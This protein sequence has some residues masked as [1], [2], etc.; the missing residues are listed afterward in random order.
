MAVK[1]IAVCA[2]DF[3]LHDGIDNAVLALA[4]QGRL[5]GV[6]CLVG[7]PAWV[8]GAQRLAGL[9]P[10]RIDI[11]LHLDLTEMPL[12]RR[13]R[14]AL[15]ALIAAACARR[16][17]RTALRAE[18][19]AQL[20]RFEQALGRP[21]A[22]IDGHQHVQQLPQV[23]DALFDV[24]AGRRAATRPWLRC[25]LRPV[26]LQAPAGAAAMQAFKPW[27]IETLGARAFAT[28][29]GRAGL[30]TNRHLLGVYGFDGD[31]DRYRR[32][33]RAWLHAAVDGDLLM[34]HPGQPTPAADDP[35]AP[36]RW[37][38]HEVL[39]GAALTQECEAA[40]V[41]LMP[42]SRIVDRPSAPHH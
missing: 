38:E 18:V 37:I 34:C 42:L 31:A 20:D 6:G 28:R 35:I 3:G 15:P 12:D 40:G 14:R 33:L 11:G 32:W 19:T 26:G 5:T 10:A 23:R 1:R 22:Y 21:P 9:D 27:L 16:L 36:A 2:D 17:S 8:T 41:L 30:A 29:A 13:L 24:L 39:A 25:G 7:G 4:E